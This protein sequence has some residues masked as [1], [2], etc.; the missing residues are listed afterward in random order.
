MQVRLLKMYSVY[1]IKIWRA[2]SI[3]QI[4]YVAQYGSFAGGEGSSWHSLLSHL[5]HP[6]DSVARFSLLAEILR[7]CYQFGTMSMY[8]LK[9]SGKRESVHFDKITS[10]VSKLCYGLDAKVCRFEKLLAFSPFQR[11]ISHP[12]MLTSTLARW[13]RRYHAEGNPRSLPWSHNLRI[14][15]VRKKN[16]RL[17][18]IFSIRLLAWISYSHPSC[19]FPNQDLLHKLQLLLQPNTPTTPF[20]LLA[21]RCQTSTN[22]R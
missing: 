17:C 12:C 21:F 4:L 3:A 15:W 2:N 8:V 13:S 11:R 22:K 19:S 10:R 1:V 16:D 9:R 14:R 7:F 6:L 18:G 5:L 20:W